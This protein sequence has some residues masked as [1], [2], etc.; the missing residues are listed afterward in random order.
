[1]LIDAAFG[2]EMETFEFLNILQVHGFPK[3]MGVL[4]HLDSF[5]VNKKLRRTKKILKHRFWTDVYPGAKLF[6]LSSL[7]KSGRY[8]KREVSNLARFISVAK[9]RPLIWRNHHPYIL[10]DRFEDVTPTATLQADPLADR[11][12]AFYGYVR[13]TY[14]RQGQPA[15]IPGLGDVRLDS[16]ARLDDPCPLVGKGRKRGLGDKDR[17][18]Y[19]PMTD[20]GGI[21]VERDATYVEI[22]DAHVVLTQGSAADGELEEGEGIRMLRNLQVSCFCNFCVLASFLVHFMLEIHTIRCDLCFRLR[23]ALL[24]RCWPMLACNFSKAAKFWRAR[25]WRSAVLLRSLADWGPRKKS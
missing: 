21:V 5:K 10:A 14:M 19:A 3:V 22:P 11:H 6:Y 9:Y 7:E 4:T 12:I 25:T 15:H 13:G 18:L 2:F 24:I 20:V 16:I 8:P 17:L 23:R 1:L